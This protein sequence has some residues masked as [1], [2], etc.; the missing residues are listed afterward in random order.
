MDPSTRLRIARLAFFQCEYCRIHEN[1]T[2]FRHQVDHI[3]SLKHGGSSLPENLALACIL[4]NRYKGSD[5][6]S[7]TS[8]TGAP[9]RLFHPRKDSWN[10]H[11]RVEGAKIEPLT[12]VGKVTLRLLRM[13]SAER[14][15]EREILQ[16]LGRY[17]R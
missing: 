14:V 16:R 12:E 11:F 2:G 15:A 4:C 9:V 8:Q 10:E 1:D 7:I 17:P 6:A 13:N 3:V 5:I